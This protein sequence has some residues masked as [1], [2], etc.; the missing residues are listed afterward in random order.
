[1]RRAPALWAAFLCVALLV[2]SVAIG[3][4]DARGPRGDDGAKP[5]AVP[6][7]MAAPAGKGPVGW[8]TYRRLDLAAHLPRGV[9]TKMF[10]SFDRE[11]GNWDGFGGVTSCLNTKTSECVIA[12][13]V[14]AGEISSIWFTRWLGPVHD[15]GRTGSFGDTGRI[16]VE[17]DGRKVLD[18]PLADVLAGK[19]GA[20]FTHP[21]VADDKQ[22]S[23]G[24]LIAVPMPYRK[25]MRVTTEHDPR[26]YQ[27]MYR[28]FADAEGVRTFDPGD[29]AQDVVDLMR[30]ASAADPKPA[31]AGTTEQATPLRLA[32]GQTQR[33]ARS[34]VPGLIGGLR[35][36][37]PQTVAPEQPPV[38]DSGRA[39]GKDGGSEFSLT[40]DPANRGVLLTRRLDRTIGGQKGRV[41]VDGKPAGEWPGNPR[42]PERWGEESLELPAALTAGKARLTIR[43]EWSG[44]QDFNEFTYWART[45]GGVPGA[46]T[47]TVDVG[48]P[49]SELSHG[50][51]IHGETWHGT[52]A[53]RYPPPDS[54]PLAT[55]RKLLRGLRLRAS[56]DGVRTVDAPL[57]EFF[58]SGYTMAPVRALMFQLDSTTGE[59]TAWWPM[60]YAREATVELY[61]GSDVHLREGTSWVRSTPSDAHARAVR[62]GTEGHF[63]ATSHA[64]ATV[65]DRSWEFLSARGDGKVVGVS[66]SMRG[67]GG[68]S[69]M[70][71]DERM[72]VDDSHTPQVH[73]TGT[74]DYYRGG[75]YFLHGTYSAP[76]NGHPARL[77]DGPGC[78]AGTE[79]CSSAYRLLLAD[80]VPFGRSMRFTIEHGLANEAPADYAAT[81]Y[82]YGQ[83]TPRLYRTD[84]VTAALTVNRRTRVEN[85]GFPSALEVASVFEGELVNPERRTARVYYTQHPVALDVTIDPA[86]QGVVLR[87]VGDQMEP[88]QRAR[89]SVDGTVLPDWYQPLG[90]RNRRWLEDSYQL[91]ASVTRG[92]RRI[93]VTLTP[94]LGTPGWASALYT[95]DSVVR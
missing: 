82:W 6:A 50:Y 60:P 44:G 19:L 10:S 75:W 43:T 72:F 7:A 90:N 20:P 61:N 15:T 49:A 69:H 88:G 92:K 35:L 57:G 21:L 66:H 40:V 3:G 38:T 89:V 17:L 23:G 42:T 14:G 94:V 55:S 8:E 83:D 27:V 85:V 13:H 67:D 2:M 95:V 91:P 73:G 71:G 36:R 47:D 22:T 46:A 63:R 76:L 1:M 37:L 45:S 18:A 34:T 84:T 32:P 79:D 78:G 86:N 59:F 24:A 4:R 62:E 68:R 51:R 74:E 70:E 93:S 52:R 64:S 41:Y 30:R 25:S 29:R 53:H 31:L 9:E 16:T 26:L 77:T 54:G 33:L 28:T 12:A 56:F 65:V 80:A 5:G 39:Y 81:T 58:G 87:R 11:G 48:D